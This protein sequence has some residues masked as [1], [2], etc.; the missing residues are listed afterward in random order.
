MNL[1][2][3]KIYQKNLGVYQGLKS[4]SVHKCKRYAPKNINILKVNTPM[5]KCEEVSI[6]EAWC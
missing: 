2:I 4:N 1:L 6:N 3:L 5:N